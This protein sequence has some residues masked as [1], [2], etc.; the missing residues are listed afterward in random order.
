MKKILVVGGAGYIGSHTCKALYQKGYKVVV[1]DNL[2]YGH[3]EFVKWG[4]FVLGDLC[5][6]DVLDKVFCEHKIDAL[7]HFAAFA[8]VGE[9]VQ[10]PHKYYQNNVCATI[11][12]LEAMRKHGVKK[13]IFSS[14]CATYG[15]PKYTPIDELH[16][17]NPINPYGRTK[18]MVEQILDDYSKAYDFRFVALRYFNAAGCDEDAQIGEKHNPE[19]HLI[20]LALDAAIGKRQD[21]KIFGTDY[22]TKDGTAIRDYIHVSDLANAHILAFE[23]LCGGGM[24]DVFNLG[25]EQGFSVKEVIE[26]AK[27][28]TKIDFEVVNAPRR[29]G[30][31]SVL[32][33]SSEK[34][35]SKLGWKPRLNSLETIIQTAWNWHKK[36]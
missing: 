16:P 20:P 35:I 2:S 34:I 29:A 21:V 5:D 6:K 19:T 9:S 12:L 3:K 28:I 7:M 31:P 24:S 13:I 14:T 33:G 18:L 4:D 15:Q 32:V 36:L 23:Y 11:N 17:Q 8:Y 25:N 1:Y 30:D 10:K 27:K 26:C 22:D